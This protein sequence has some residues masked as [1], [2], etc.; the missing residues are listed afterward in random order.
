MPGSDSGCGGKQLAEDEDEDEDEQT[1]YEL[2]EV[3]SSW[4]LPEAATISYAVSGSSFCLSS[5][6]PR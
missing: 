3:L 1:S 6:R 5:C 4:H 2:P